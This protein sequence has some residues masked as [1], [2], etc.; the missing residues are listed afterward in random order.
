MIKPAIDAGRVA[1]GK[2]KEED[3]VYDPQS[4]AIVVKTFEM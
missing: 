4:E 3:T 2:E 1:S